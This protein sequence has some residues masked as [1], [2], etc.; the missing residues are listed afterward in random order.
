MSK[1]TFVENLRN[2]LLVAFCFTMLWLLSKNTVGKLATSEMFIF[3]G[4][5]L[6]LIYESFKEIG[7]KKIVYG[8]VGLMW[9]MVPQYRNTFFYY[10]EKLYGVVVG[11]CELAVRTFEIAQGET[12]LFLVL[13]MLLVAIV[14]ASG[15]IEKISL[16]LV[17]KAK[18]DVRKI[19]S[20]LAYLTCFSAGVLDGATVAFLFGNIVFTIC[21]IAGISFIK[22]LLMVAFVSGS[23]G[24]FT[25]IGE[26][27]NII[28][29]NNLGYSINFFLV[30]LTIPAIVFVFI[31]EKMFL[32]GI[33]GHV[34]EEEVRKKIGV[35]EEK[36]N[37]LQKMSI[38]GISV[39]MVLLMLHMILGI[40]E[41]QCVLIALGFAFLGVNKDSFSTVIK[42]WKS[43]VEEVF[44]LP[45]IFLGVHVL[46][47][48]EVFKKASDAMSNVANQYI[49]G[50]ILM[51]SVSFLSSV[52]DNIVV[53]DVVTK[54]IA[55]MPTQSKYLAEITFM[56]VA[57]GGT[58]TFIGSLQS[59][60]IYI[61]IKGKG[62]NIGFLEWTKYIIL[63]YILCATLGT[64]YSFRHLM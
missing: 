60:A 12:I 39:L 57:L 31:A 23:C 36:L 51:P 4:I 40:A 48:L 19:L 10:L 45:G 41:Y 54:T 53:A 3:G 58:L 47:Y 22:P 25:K 29:G 21:E 24:I 5:I 17:K 64:I 9:L 7:K 63:P 35:K 38:V 18:G 28:G 20:W 26:V 8:G 52:T 37:K 43:E 11:I 50:S 14:N 61:I 27:T 46:E 62:E 2:Y 49:L 33:T 32:K 42:K 56:S 30:N 15:L 44:F 13:L 55:K 59:I 1:K 34:S 16:L 6:F